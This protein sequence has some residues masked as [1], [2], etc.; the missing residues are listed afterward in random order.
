MKNH[1]SKTLLGLMTNVQSKVT[2]RKYQSNNI[3]SKKVK[4][5]SLS[6]N[7]CQQMQ[8]VESKA[9]SFIPKHLIVVRNPGGATSGARENKD[10]S[11]SL[12]TMGYYVSLFCTK[13]ACSVVLLTL[14]ECNH[15]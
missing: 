6:V 8:K 4:F 12:S 5:T 7:L 13:T 3:C 14:W 1:H 10:P 15:L 9:P 2:I 11:V